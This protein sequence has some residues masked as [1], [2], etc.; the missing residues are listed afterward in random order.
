[1]AVSRDFRGQGLAT[2]MHHAGFHFAYNVLKCDY[3]YADMVSSETI[4]LSEKFG[5][6]NLKEF[7]FVDHVKE[8]YGIEDETKVTDPQIIKYFENIKEIEKSYRKGPGRVVAC[9]L[10][11]KEYFENL[12]Q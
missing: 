1:M 6:K 11:L 4:Y 9:V 3:L 8:A 10:Y 12:T 7:T 5:F 2:F